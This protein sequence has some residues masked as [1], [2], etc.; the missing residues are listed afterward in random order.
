MNSGDNITHF[1]MDVSDVS[2][3]KNLVL[4][5]RVYIVLMV[6]QVLNMIDFHLVNE[7]QFVS[8]CGVEPTACRNQEPRLTWVLGSNHRHDTCSF[9]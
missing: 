9:C 5:I 1:L 4:Y 7:Q 6:F 8:S 2:T 3:I